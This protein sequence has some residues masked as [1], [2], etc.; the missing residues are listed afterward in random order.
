[1]N[2]QY[3]FMGGMARS[4]STLLCAILQQN[5]KLYVSEQ[6]PVCDLTYKLNLL[7]DNNQFYQ[8]CPN[9][10]RRINTLKGLI[11]NY[12]QDVQQE[13]VIDKFRSWGTPYNFSMIESL[14]TDKAKII[15]P[16]RDVIEC[17]ASLLVLIKKHKNKKSFIDIR[18]ESKGLDITDENRCEE[19]INGDGGLM[20]NLFAMEHSKYEPNHYHFVEYND[21]VNDPSKV[22]KNL[23]EFLE[24]DHYEHNFK[25]INFTSQSRDSDYY[26]IPD[27]HKVRKK[28]S[29]KS[30]NP[31][32]ILPNSIIDKYSGMEFWRSC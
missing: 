28:I 15:C 30:V 29:K 18:L 3:Y 19:I 26:G 9:E 16:V 14:Y 7:F 21:L 24:I 10:Q 27:L 8:G 25:Y 11:D 6:S 22:M 23:Y 4:G 13:I 32:D 31:S 2:H 12:Y 17:V 20:H 5:P 1:M